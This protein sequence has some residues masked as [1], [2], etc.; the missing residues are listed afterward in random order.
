MMQGWHSTDQPTGGGTPPTNP[1]GVAL[2]RP[3]HWGWHSTD[4][5]TRGGT[6][7]THPPGVALQRPTH[8]G[9][10]FNDPPTGAAV[11]C[12]QATEYTS[13]YNFSSDNFDQS[14]SYFPGQLQYTSPMWKMGPACGRKYKHKI[15]GTKNNRT[16]R[17]T[18]TKLCCMI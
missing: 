2:H 6:P 3:I 8:Q 7:Q 9:W 12:P 15:S 5:S 4:P 14:A 17:N 13:N 1:P 18:E 11:L 10:H 16:V